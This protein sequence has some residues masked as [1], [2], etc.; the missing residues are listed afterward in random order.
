[1]TSSTRSIA[2]VRSGRHE[3]GVTRSVPAPA[4]ATSQPIACSSETTVSA[5]MAMPATSPGSVDGQVD[6][7]DGLAGLDAVMPT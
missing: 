1:M 3:G 4:S 6:H 5:S 7:R 2:S